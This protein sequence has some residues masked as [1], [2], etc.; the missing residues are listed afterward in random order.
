MDMSGLTWVRVVGGSWE[1]LEKTPRTV[2]L[3]NG[4]GTSSSAF[5]INPNKSEEDQ[6]FLVRGDI[7][8]NDIYDAEIFGPLAPR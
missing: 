5:Q 2:T 1:T 4:A 6:A 3:W 7:H 8:T